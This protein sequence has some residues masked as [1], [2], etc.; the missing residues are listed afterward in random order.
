M[1]GCSKINTEVSDT[2]VKTVESNDCRE[3]SEDDRD[4]NSVLA[5]TWEKAKFFY[6]DK[7]KFINLFT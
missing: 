3:I 1:L 6:K 4:I 2:S 7:Q 5:T